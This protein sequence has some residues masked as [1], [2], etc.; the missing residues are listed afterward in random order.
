MPNVLRV[1]AFEP[2]GGGPQRRPGRASSASRSTTRPP[3]SSRSASIG[4][5]PLDGVLDVVPV[6]GARQEGPAR[7]RRS[8]C[9]CDPDALRRGGR[10]LPRRD[11]DDRP[12]LADRG[13]AASLRARGRR[14]RR[15]SRVKRVHAARTA[16]H[17][18]GRD[19][20][21]GRAA[22]GYAARAAAPARGRA[23][24]TSAMS[25]RLDAGARRLRP[26][27]GRGER[28]RRQHDAR[29]ARASAGSAPARHHVP[30]R[31][32]RRAARGDRPR[33]RLRRARRLARCE[34]STPASS[35]TRATSP[36]RSTAA[37]S[38]RPTST[39]RSAAHTDGAD[40]LRH[41]PRRP[42]RLPPR[43]AG[44]RA[45]RRAP[46]ARRGRDRQGHRARAGAAASASTT[47][48]SCRRRPACRA[49]V[50]TGIAIDAAGA[51]AWSTRSS[52]CSARAC[53]GRAPCAAG[54]AATG[55]VVQL[56]ARAPG[57]GSSGAGLRAWSRAIAADLG[58]R[59]RP[60]ASSPI[61]RGSAFLRPPDAG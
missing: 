44:R 9:W 15:E 18:Q 12:A 34:V 57:R 51:G 23:R 37:S 2:A 8:R 19:R 61:A 6:A 58:R 5:A 36:T 22:G 43:P 30:R 32:A 39:A 3:R 14:G 20:R 45:A 1:L 25:G 48:P 47:W 41:Q 60:C 4:C 7:R 40:R 52:A 11:L 55:V 24:M 56:D 29:L 33:A 50:E 46:P 49:G 42:R 59:Q 28:R 38:A 21:P 53:R 17:R 35:P 10:R 26:A 54:C 13:A 31:L 27:R 16:R